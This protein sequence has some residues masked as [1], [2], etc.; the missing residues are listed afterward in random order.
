MPYKDITGTDY[1]VNAK[2]FINQ[3]KRTVYA[4]KEQANDILSGLL[5]DDNKLVALDGGYIGC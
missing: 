2:E 3:L 5:I 1:E 4:C